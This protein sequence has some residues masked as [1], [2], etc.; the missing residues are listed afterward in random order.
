RLVTFVGGPKATLEGG[1]RSAGRGVS[2]VMYR[3]AH[4]QGVACSA[5]EPGSASLADRERPALLRLGTRAQPRVRV[6][7]GRRYQLPLRDRL[8]SV[9]LAWRGVH[10]GRRA[11][12]APPRP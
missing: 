10:L 5:Q 12:G 1:G 6:R 11:R 4:G 9:A 2:R 8:S 7:R 3:S